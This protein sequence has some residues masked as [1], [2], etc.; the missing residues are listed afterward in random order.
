MAGLRRGANLRL[1]K[2]PVEVKRKLRHL[3]LV[4]D[5]T[6]RV[7]ARVEHAVVKTIKAAVKLTRLIPR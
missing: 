2:G 4:L 1:S 6:L 3:R 7:N 5:T